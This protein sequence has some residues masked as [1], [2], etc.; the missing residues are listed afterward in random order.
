MIKAIILASGRGERMMPLTK[1][2]PK[3]LLKINGKPMIECAIDLLASYGVKNIGIN[4]FYLGD[5][6]KKYLGDGKKLNVNIA[7]VEEKFL[8]GTAGG[9]KNVARTLN[10]TEPFFAISS[11]ILMNFPLDQVY[12]FHLKHGGIA[13]LCCY[14]RPKEAVYKSGV[15][16]FDKKTNNIQ[17]F[18][19]RPRTEEE[20]ISQWVNSSVYVFS[21]KILDYIP[22]EVDNSPVVDLAKHVF[23]VLLKKE[24]MYAFPIDGEKYYQLGMDTPDRLPR[25]EN[26]IKSGK[27]KPLTTS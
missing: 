20:I 13:T 15:I 12:K 1:N 25:A 26:D 9:V 5:Q 24:K 4:L 19:E 17:K 7:Y 14:W 11:D 27:F 16:L 2:T 18:L 10:V 3:P 23:P 8:T 22:D 21:P 6:I